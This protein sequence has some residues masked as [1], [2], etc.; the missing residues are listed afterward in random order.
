MRKGAFFN[1]LKANRKLLIIWGFL[2]LLAILSTQGIS[3]R[4]AELFDSIEDTALWTL[5]YLVRGLVVLILVAALFLL[6]KGV[7]RLRARL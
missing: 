1:A 3:L 4:D 2:A 6:Y 5:V 7:Q